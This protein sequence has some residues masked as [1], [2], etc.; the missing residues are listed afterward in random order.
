MTRKNLFIIA[1]ILITALLALWVSIAQGTSGFDGKTINGVQTLNNG[2]ANSLQAAQYYQQ[3]QFLDVRWY[4]ATGDGVANDTTALT[5]WLAAGDNLYLPAGTYCLHSALTKTVAA[6]DYLIMRGGGWDSIIRWEGASKGTMITL[7]GTGTGGLLVE[8]LVIDCN[9]LASTGIKTA[10]WGHLVTFRRCLFQL[11]LQDDANAQAMLDNFVESHNGVIE[12]CYFFSG[13]AIGVN[14]NIAGAA[15]G[16]GCWRI[17]DNE[18]QQVNNWCIKGAN[19]STCLVQNNIIDQ[20]WANTTGYGFEFD[21]SDQ[22]VIQNNQME[23]IYNAAISL[24]PHSAPPYRGKT[25]AILNNKFNTCGVTADIIVGDANDLDICGNAFLRGADAAM[26]VVVDANSLNTLIGT[27][28][29]YSDSAGTRVP[30]FSAYVSDYSASTIYRTTHKLDLRSTAAVS[31]PHLRW[32]DTS[33]DSGARNWAMGNAVALGAYGSLGLYRSAAAGGDPLVGS[34]VAEWDNAGLFTAY[35]GMSVKNGATSAGYQ[36]YYE[37][38]DAGTNKVRLWGQSLPADANS[39]HVFTKQVDLSNANI[40]ALAA[41]VE[42]VAAPGA[43]RWLELV[44]ASFWMDYGSEALAEPSSPDDLVI[45]YDT[46]TG[47]AASATI[48]ASGFIT[49]AAD[50]MAFAVP[51]S[52]AGTAASALVNKNLALINTGGDYTGNASNDT[53]LRVIVNYRIHDSLGL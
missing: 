20:L 34:R 28:T 19:V 16:P 33:G 39:F 53:V 30:L 13:T 41:G 8:N 18:F 11:G 32:L 15:S 5:N 49:A 29:A 21:A 14:L 9:N 27:N 6:G 22:I 36:D 47:P 45:E 12:Q 10:A 52:V 31:G 37:D 4:G 35:A 24:N 38:S 44:S 46:G 3:D 40:K 50:T 1:T 2:D 43:S 51:V 42:L 7:T 48:V 17:S 25:G 26:A 23:G